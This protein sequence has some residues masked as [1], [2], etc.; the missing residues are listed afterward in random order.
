M[1]TPDFIRELRRSAG[2]QLL[3]LP[4]VSAVVLDERDRV[5]LVRR[6]DSGAWTLIGGIPDPGEEPG[7]AIVREVYEETAV[8]V[9]LE[10]VLSVGATPPVEYPNGDRCQYLNICFLARPTGGTARVNDD[11]SSEVGWF[12]LD[13]LPPLDG[14]QLERIARARSGEAATWFAPPV[15]ERVSG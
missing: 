14:L 3:W 13:G 1:A 6:S 2:H 10:R 11:E 12:P 4:G 7:E 9:A 5:L 15:S 8:R